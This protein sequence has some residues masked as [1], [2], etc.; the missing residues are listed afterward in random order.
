MTQNICNII[1]LNHCCCNFAMFPDTFM[2]L[3]WK[4]QLLQMFVAVL[5]LLV[6][7][8]VLLWLIHIWMVCCYMGILCPCRKKTDA[9]MCHWHSGPPFLKAKDALS[10]HLIFRM[11]TIQDRRDA[12]VPKQTKKQ[13]QLQLSKVRQFQVSEKFLGV[14]HLL[15]D[16]EYHICGGCLFLLWVM[17]WRGIRIDLHSL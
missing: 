11:A 17:S 15:I 13:W 7:V 1:L 14:L 4:L 5:D 12:N 2:E 3:V 10:I 6:F 9:A 16:W 8:T